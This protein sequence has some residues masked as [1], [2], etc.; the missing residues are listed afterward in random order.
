MSLDRR[1]FLRLAVGSAGTNLVGSVLPAFAAAN[2]TAR[3][4]AFDAFTTFDPRP[5]FVFAEELFPGQGAE[6]SNVWRT[7]QFEYQWLRAASGHY[8]DFWQATDGALVYAAQLLKLELTADKRERL[9]GAYRKLKAWPDSA[10]A[11]RALKESGIRL[12][13]LSNA[14]PDLLE[15]WI[16]N[17]GLQGMYEHVLSTDTI[18]TFKPDPR[19]Y[20]MAIDAFELNR[21][22]IAFAAFG[23]WD[24]AGAKWFG[25][26][27]FWV[28]RLKL[29]VEELGVAPDGTGP[30]LAEL[31]SFVAG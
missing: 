28:N 19:A 21:E 10:P 14:T 26:T 12:A 7:R 31:V 9:M 17:S 30:T 3:A 1:D 15:A 18:R 25:Y 22:Q 16:G 5:V 23:G 8:A 4:I 2:K 29:P 20:Q 11:L 13:L 24:A 6:L 27:T